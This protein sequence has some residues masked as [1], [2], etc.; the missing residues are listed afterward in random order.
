MT[1]SYVWIW[2]QKKSEIIF[3]HVVHYQLKTSKTGWIVLV[4]LLNI[5]MNSDESTSDA[6]SYLNDSHKC[7]LQEKMNVF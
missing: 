2:C 1:D 5:V 3:I 6:F 7:L 4:R